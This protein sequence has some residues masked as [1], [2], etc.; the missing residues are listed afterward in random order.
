M[1][2]IPHL[3]QYQGS[4]RIIAPKIL[5]YFPNN[6]NR[7]IEPFA[8]TCSISILI[9]CEKRC[10]H[11]LVNDINAP[12]IQLMEQCI[13]NPSLLSET[14]TQIWNGQFAEGQ[15]NVDYYYK[16]REEFNTG[17]IDPA[18]MLFLL[19]R[20]VKGAIRYNTQGLMNQGCDKRRNRTRPKVIESNANKISELLKGKIEFSS[21]DY[22][23]I[24]SI[25]KP[26]DLL[27]LDPPYQGTSRTDT[28]RDNRYIQGVSYEEFIE[29]LEKLNYRGINYI[30]SY[31]G[32][33]G[34]KQIGKKLPDSLNL[35][36][37]YINAGVSTQSTLNGKKEI[38]YESLYL[39]PGLK[40][41]QNNI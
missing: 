22:K 8:G 13:N 15:N 24:L 7:L 27:Y 12:L 6:I 20:V 32:M 26:N 10:N 33:T 28:S 17:M 19:T 31:D 37:L 25:A 21:V 41:L 34:E 5:K 38:T 39:S 36:H 2:T 30:V 16:I 29:E 4:K 23:E 40:Q 14:Y 18:R 1:A 35:T 3:M 9:A 11:F